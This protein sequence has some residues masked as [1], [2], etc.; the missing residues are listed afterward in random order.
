MKEWISKLSLKYLWIL[1]ILVIPNFIC[2]IYFWPGY[3]QADHQY[4]IS[5]LINGEPNQLHSML[6]T[7]M[8]FPFLYLLPHYSCYWF[9]QIAIFLFCV[10]F[11]V[12]IL[13]KNFILKR[14]IIFSFFMSLFPTFLMYNMLYSSDIIFSYLLIPITSLLICIINNK[15]NRLHNKYFVLLL[16]FIVLACLMRKNGVLILLIMFIASFFVDCIKN[17]L[18]I[19]GCGFSLFFV[20]IS[21]PLFSLIFNATESPSQEMLS[22]PSIQIASVYSNNGYIPEDCRIVFEKYHSKEYWVSNFS[23]WSAD[24]LKNGLQLNGEFISAY[25]KTGFF[26]LQTYIIS[27]LKFICPYCINGYESCYGAEEGTVFTGISIDFSQ[28]D[29]FTL[30][31]LSKTYKNNELETNKKVSEYIQEFGG[32]HSPQWYKMSSVDIKLSTMPF[33]NYFAKY[34]LF[35]RALPFYFLIIS[36]FVCLI[37]KKWKDYLFVSIPQWAIIISLLLFSPVAMMRYSV[38]IYY[39]LPILVIYICYCVRQNKEVL[40]FKLFSKWNTNRLDG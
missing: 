20:F 8:S 37:F 38:E 35:N 30:D 18:F 11:S 1:L 39:S 21:S 22:V 25:A 26:N 23:F 40:C 15:R 6:W 3:F 9:L 32:Q 33:I 17:K 10:V 5:C 19:F 31:A 2:W 16:I 24:P 7:L 4:S 34:V 13:T 28:N 36:F 29:N 27:Y 14:P 12:K